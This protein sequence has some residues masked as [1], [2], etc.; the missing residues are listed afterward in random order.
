MRNGY[1]Y[2]IVARSADDQF[3]FSDTA[4]AVPIHFSPTEALHLIRATVENNSF[5]ALEWESP[6][7]DRAESVII[8]RDRGNGFSET[9][10]QPAQPG[11]NKYQDLDTDVQNQTYTYRGFV[12]DSCGDYTPLGR[13]GNNMV[14]TAK[15]VAGSV[16]INWTPY[17]GWENGVDAY[18]VELYN[19]S[20]QSFEE[21]ASVPGNQTSGQMMLAN[22]DNPSTAIAW[23]PGNPGRLFSAVRTN[24]VRLWSLSCLAQTHLLL[25]GTDSMRNLPLR[26]HLYRHTN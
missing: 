10:R 7:V 3:S 24:P 9:D 14:L 1:A 11:L 5:V 16:N 26:V 2:R 15:K 18:S 6:P 4:H 13:H 22:W 20:S 19:E 12:L 21:V 8:E 17:S 25:M 23:W